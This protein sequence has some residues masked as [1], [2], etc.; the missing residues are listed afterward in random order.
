MRSPRS[1][2]LALRAQN[3]ERQLRHVASWDGPEIRLAD[4]RTLIQF[5]SNDYLGLA[6]CDELREALAEGARRFGAGA[7][8]SRLI[9]GSHAAHDELEQLL[10]DWKG[11]ERALSF[12]SGYATAVGT[13]TSILGKDDFV[14]LDKLCH[15]SLI[16][17]ARHSGAT[18]RVFP[19]N[20]LEKLESHLKWAV[21]KA[22]SSAESRILIA[23][24]SVFSMDGDRADLAAIAELKTRF[25]GLLMVDEAHAVGVIGPEGRGLA[26]ELGVAD[27]I[28][29]QM[30]TLSKALGVSGG[31]LAASADWIDLLINRARSFIYSTAPPPALASA[32]AEAVRLVR[33]DSGEQRRQALWRN[34]REL[35]AAIARTEVSQ[36]A[37]VPVVV[38][39]SEA[40]LELSRKL[41]KQGLLVPA[42][43]FPTVPRRTARLRISMSALHTSEQISRLAAAV[44]VRE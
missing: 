32:A 2:L 23:T 6:S 34:L 28:D 29:F 20:D 13:L 38:G 7:G 10:A 26:N 30:G 17:G 31:Y 39:E 15:A 5:A 16:D 25:G 14:I 4:G 43:R 41:E 40:A 44:P 27:A 21:S 11:T 18:I 36:S 33:G 35:D 8:A 42:I 1:E 19:H 22:G 3:L 9:T 37:I 24:E 12:S